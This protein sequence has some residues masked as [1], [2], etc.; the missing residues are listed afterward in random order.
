[1]SPPDPPLGD[2]LWPPF[3]PPTTL[4]FIVFFA[5]PFQSIFL[6]FHPSRVQSSHNFPFAGGKH[7]T[8]RDLFSDL[9]ALSPFYFTLPPVVS[10]LLLPPFFCNKCSCSNEH[11]LSRPCLSLRPLASGFPTFL[12]WVTLWL[13]VNTEKPRPLLL[14]SAQER[15]VIYPFSDSFFPYCDAPS[16]VPVGRLPS[17]L[18]GPIPPPQFRSARLSLFHHTDPCIF[19]I[20]PFIPD[21]FYNASCTLCPP[22]SSISFLV[23]PFGLAIWSPP[24]PP[25]PSLLPPLLYFFHSST[26]YLVHPELSLG[27]FLDGFPGCDVPFYLL[28][29]I[30]SNSLQFS[31]IAQFPQLFFSYFSCITNSIS[32]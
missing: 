18:F 32:P 17:F 3:F 30:L 20:S 21:F 31:G 5:S 16:P 24:S 2:E 10:G 26:A 4:L 25:I 6:S 15:E 28:S 7:I 23:S 13:I 19:M 12:T 11:M 9:S 29:G 1:M 27:Y 8:F 14:L 22:F